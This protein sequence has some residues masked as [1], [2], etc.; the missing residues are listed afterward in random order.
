MHDVPALRGPNKKI[1]RSKQALAFCVVR[2]A[3]SLHKSGIHKP[4]KSSA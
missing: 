3:I 1:Y 4:D 2:A